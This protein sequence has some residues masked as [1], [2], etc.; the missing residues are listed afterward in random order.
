MMTSYAFILGVVPLMFATGAGAHSRV[1]I[2]TAVFG[3]ML[4]ETMVGILV[5]PVLFIVI[6]SIA[7]S[8]MSVFRR[9]LGGGNEASDASEA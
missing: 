8:I 5:S 4:E 9:G 7:V 2:G 1:D 6:T 3:G